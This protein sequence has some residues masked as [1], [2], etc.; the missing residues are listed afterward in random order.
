MTREEMEEEQVDDYLRQKKKVVDVL[1][2]KMEVYN[3][4]HK[5]Q[6]D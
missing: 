3:S 6:Q 1:R 5:T 2:S 4:N